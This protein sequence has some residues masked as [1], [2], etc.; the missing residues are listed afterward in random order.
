MVRILLTKLDSAI[1][2]YGTIGVI[3]ISGLGYYLLSGGSEN[4]RSEEKPRHTNEPDIPVVLE[5]EK[6]DRR[7]KK[8]KNQNVVEPEPTPTPQPR[9]VT[10][11]RV[12]SEER[13][14]PKQ[15]TKP[16][17]VKET[18]NSNPVKAEQKK[19]QS[20]SVERTQAPNSK[21]KNKTKKPKSKVEEEDLNTPVRD[22]NDDE[23]WTV[24]NK[25]KQ[26]GTQAREQDQQAK[27]ELTTLLQ[28][29]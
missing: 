14:K 12:Q 28:E 9:E 17:P 8:K 13:E 26:T 15:E 27:E 19:P 5:D 2:L 21:K 6:R 29:Y 16:N 11:E 23:G 7:H 22:N 1:Y 24:V 20:E 25:K 3:A 4:S 18:N 10:R